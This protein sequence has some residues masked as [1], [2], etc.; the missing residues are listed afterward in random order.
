MICIILIFNSIVQIVGMYRVCQL[1]KTTVQNQ[2]KDENANQ[3]SLRAHA[4]L[5]LQRVLRGSICCLVW[6]RSFKV[7]VLK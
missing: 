1:N 5:V 4:L 7:N 3:R 6:A 2:R